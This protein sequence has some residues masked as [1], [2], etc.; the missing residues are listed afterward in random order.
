MSAH[1]V[2]VTLYVLVA[3]VAVLDIYLATDKKEGN[4]FSEVIWKISA[5]R[6]LVRRMAS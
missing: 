4:T 5:R 2:E 6:P 3:L 1:A